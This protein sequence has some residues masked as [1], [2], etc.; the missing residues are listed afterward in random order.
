M[1]QAVAAAASEACNV[2]RMEAVTF[3]GEVAG[4]LRELA[5][6]LDNE[7]RFCVLLWAPSAA[8]LAMSWASARSTAAAAASTAQVT[9]NLHQ[10][11]L[12]ALQAHCTSDTIAA[13]SCGCLEQLEPDQIELL[14]AMTDV[15]QL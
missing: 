6:D 8:S 10:L 4:P 14:A 3:P 15:V 13:C 9:P 1:A 7:H 12:P 2:Q 11:L 5:L